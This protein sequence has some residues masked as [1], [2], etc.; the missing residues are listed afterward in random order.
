MS[1]FK[2]VIFVAGLICIVF[3]MSSSVGAYCRIFDNDRICEA[4]IMGDF[5]SGKSVVYRNV[6]RKMKYQ[7]DFLDAHFIVDDENDDSIDGDRDRF[8]EF[9]GHLRTCVARFRETMDPRF[10][11]GRFKVSYDIYNRSLISR[12][13]VAIIVYDASSDERDKPIASVRRWKNFATEADKH[14]KIMLIANKWESVPDKDMC[15]KE[16]VD[17]AYDIGADK[18]ST[19]SNSTGR[20]VNDILEFI[21]DEGYWRDSIRGVDLTSSYHNKSCCK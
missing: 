16:L 5:D 13:D 3:G 19:F 7:K 8:Y 15:L 2:K 10:L 18:W 12:L 6:I 11:D 21:E 17:I 9:D 4:V 1:I 20:G 14:C